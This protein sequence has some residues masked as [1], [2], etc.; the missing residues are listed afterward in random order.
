[1]PDQPRGTALLMWY[2]EMSG[3]LE[4]LVGFDER[5]RITGS[6]ATRIPGREA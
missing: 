2:R 6:A 1:M 4:R 5:V 3:I